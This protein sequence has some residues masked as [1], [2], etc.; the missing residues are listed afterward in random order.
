MSAIAIAGLV[1]VLPRVAPAGSRPASG[2]KS[3]DTRV[4]LAWNGAALEAIRQARPGPPIAARQ[5]AIVH[6]CIYDAWAA[7]DATAVGTE[8][9]GALRRPSNEHTRARKQEAVSFA[10]H[11]ALAD[12]FPAQLAIFDDLLSSLGWDPSN[13]SADVTTPAGVGNVACAA[14]LQSRHGDGSNQLGDLNGGAPYSDYT[15]Y[16]PVNTVD[17]VVD[18]NHW[19]PQRFSNGLTPGYIAPHWGLVRPFALSSGDALRPRPPALYPDEAY[20]TQAEELVTISARLT[21]RQKAIAEDWADG[22][23]TVLPPGHWNLFAQMVARRDRQSLD[24]DVKLFFLVANAVFDAGIASWDCKRVYDYVRPITAIRFLFAGQT[25]RAWAGPFLGTQDID[26][27]TWLPYQPGTFITPPFA[28]YVSGHSTFSAAA[29]EV[30]RRFTRSDF[31]GGWV[32]VREG[33]SIVEPGLSPRRPILLFWLT[34]TAAANQAGMSR[35]YGG[36]HFRDG[37]LEGRM[38]GRRVGARVWDKA[39]RLFAGH[40]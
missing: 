9:G 13:T 14:V 32:V 17:V 30:L 11:R 33:S 26:G 31:F 10:A 1:L 35:R 16:V 39:Q 7:Y 40:N 2:A 34:F 28:E 5:L 4:V 22:P 6:T 19:Q 38:L 15:G 21:D 8:L 36:I 37:D 27:A 20:T 18:P 23:S 12:L 25:I 29:A 3:D 24:E